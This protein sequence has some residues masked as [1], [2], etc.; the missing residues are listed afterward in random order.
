MNLNDPVTTLTEA[1]EREYPPAVAK[2]CNDCP[3][4]R[5]ATPGWLGPHTAEEWLDQAHGE[6]AI[7]CHQTLP[8]GGGWAPESCQCRGVASFRANVYKQ[9][10][11]PTIEVGPRDPD[12]FESNAEFLDYHGG[13]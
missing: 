13:D 12:V 11:N 3:W 10:R 1:M 6:A 4:R 9:P 7:A 8:T 5:N 2:P